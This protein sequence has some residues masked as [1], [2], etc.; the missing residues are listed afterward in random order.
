MPDDAA[1]FHAQWRRS[2][3]TR[4]HP[5]HTILDGVTGK[6]VYAGTYVA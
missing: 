2:L 3:T 4:G 1:Y 5:E 6:G